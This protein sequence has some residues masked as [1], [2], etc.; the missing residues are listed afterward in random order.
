MRRSVTTTAMLSGG[1][2]FSSCR[3]RGESTQFHEADITL[4]NLGTGRVGQR[5]NPRL[6]PPMN[7]Q[8]R[9]VLGQRNAGLFLVSPETGFYDRRHWATKY[10]RHQ[11]HAP[12]IEE[13]TTASGSTPSWPTTL[14]GARTAAHHGKTSAHPSLQIN[15]PR[16]VGGN[17][18]SRPEAAS[19]L[20]VREKVTPG[21]QE[22]AL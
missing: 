10:T 8:D 16:L 6:V 11:G 13:L 7:R 12:R 20:N 18:M 2:L 3:Q 5:C 21:P 9:R 15:C 17:P 4:P 1:A 14:S 22:F 19:Q